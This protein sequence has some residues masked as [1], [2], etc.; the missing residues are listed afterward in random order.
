MFMI[1]LMAT[2]IPE[3]FE[4]FKTDGERRFYKFLEAFARQDEQHI[5]WYKPDIEGKD[6]DFIFISRLPT[7]S[8]FPGAKRMV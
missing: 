2:M 5:T 3:N 6:P 8:R 4:E 7:G 1:K